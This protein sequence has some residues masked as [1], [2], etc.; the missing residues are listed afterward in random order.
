MG[1]YQ[2]GKKGRLNVQ[3]LIFLTL[4]TIYIKEKIS[5]I[6]FYNAEGKLEK[7]QYQ[8]RQ[9]TY[10]VSLRRVRATIAAVQKQ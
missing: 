1:D 2:V 5:V 6:I 3:G 10:N 4:H 9:Y 8:D 7:S